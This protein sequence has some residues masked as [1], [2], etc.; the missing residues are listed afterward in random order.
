[1]KPRACIVAILAVLTL[2]VGVGFGIDEPARANNCG[3]SCEEESVVLSAVI[4]GF[5][6]SQVGQCTIG[7]DETLEKDLYTWA[8]TLAIEG[9]LDG[10][11]VAWFQNGT[12]DG[13]VTQD[14]NVFA[15]NLTITG[16]VGDDVRF[17]G[18]NIDI[19]GTVTG[20]VMAGASFVRIGEDAVIEGDLLVGAGTVTIDGEVKGGVRMATG[21]LTING[22]IAGD[23]YVATDGGITMGEDA[24]I[25]G[26]LHYEGPAEIEFRH[27]AIR[28]AITFKTQD[29]DLEDIESAIG[30]FT[31]VFAT[32]M[33]AYLFI[34]AL[35]A[36]SIIF[37]FT[38]D[39]ANRTA[40]ILRKKP[41]KSL[42]IGFIAAICLPIICLIMLLL[43]LTIPLSIVVFLMYLVALYI[44]KFYVA[45]WLGKL[46]LRG[47]PADAS[48]I[49]PML[50]GLTI[51]YL[52]T[53]IPYLGFLVSLLVIF[54]G[55]GALLQRKETRLN[56][57][58]EP[59]TAPEPPGLPD[60]FPAGPRG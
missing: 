8:Q 22:T 2:V 51:L 28:G 49:P 24:S 23:A 3:V 6:F 15:Q 33:H 45:A 20:N 59:P 52:V 14:V 29:K 5:H 27:G 48:P 38:K 1:M 16:E 55:L 40:E 32:V 34:A 25:G 44:A 47:R 10:D 26:D 43:V 18:N 41:L 4:G 36:G 35:I 56:G 9:T 30:R 58:F 42:G 12:I 11:L 53:W 13:T 50:L 17:A 54:F 21:H 46:I 37:A 19:L 57:A 60:T 31:G 7:P 39:H